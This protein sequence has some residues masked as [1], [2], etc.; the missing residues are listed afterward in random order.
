MD[1]SEIKR[2]GE[3]QRMEAEVHICSGRTAG[4]R[5]GVEGDRPGDLQ[6][7]CTGSQQGDLLGSRREDVPAGEE[8]DGKVVKPRQIRR[9]LRE[10]IVKWKVLFLNIKNRRI[11]FIFFVQTLNNTYIFLLVY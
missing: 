7:A 9:L 4:N 6:E 8:E 10:S 11:N 2:A 5:L 1:L 3:V